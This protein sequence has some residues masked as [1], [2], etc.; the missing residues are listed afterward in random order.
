VVC[1]P[2]LDPKDGAYAFCPE[3]AHVATDPNFW[4][5]QLACQREKGKNVTLHI[6]AAER[7]LHALMPEGKSWLKDFEVNRSSWVQL[8]IKRT[9]NW[10]ET[11]S[12][13]IYDKLTTVQPSIFLERRK[14]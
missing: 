9:K 13:D 1:R 8:D 12:P 14:R 4:A 2:A 10:L 6:L 11:Y 5:H 7:H 3:C